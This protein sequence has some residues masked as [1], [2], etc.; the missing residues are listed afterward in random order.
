MIGWHHEE[1]AKTCARIMRKRLLHR[2]LDLYHAV[3]LLEKYAFVI[4]GVIIKESNRNG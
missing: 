3:V 2:A 1:E 4:I